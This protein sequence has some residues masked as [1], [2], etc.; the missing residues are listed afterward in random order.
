MQSLVSRRQGKVVKQKIPYI[1]NGISFVFSHSNIS[2]GFRLHLLEGKLHV[3]RTHQNCEIATTPL[4]RIVEMDRLIVK[5]RD[6]SNATRTFTRLL[7]FD[8]MQLRN[9]VPCI[10]QIQ[11]RNF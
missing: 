1:V 11:H 4:H 10:R 7:V 8:T 5:T 3:T 9:S 2:T 6:H